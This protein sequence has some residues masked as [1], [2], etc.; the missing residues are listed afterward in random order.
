W[1]APGVGL[2]K[3]VFEH[4]DNSTSTIELTK[5]SGGGN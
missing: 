5:T 4:N 1:F 3:L 2:I